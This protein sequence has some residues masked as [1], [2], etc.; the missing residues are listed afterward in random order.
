MNNTLRNLSTLVTPE[1]N[2]LTLEQLA[3]AYPKDLNP[4][5]LATAFSKVFKLIISV[6]KKYY[7]LDQSD[8]ASFSL[9]V[10][11]KCLQTYSNDKGAFTTYFTTVLVNKLRGQCQRLFTDKRKAF[12]CGI[13]FEVLTEKGFDITATDYT[14]V[15]TQLDNIQGF[16]LDQRELQ[17]CKYIMEGY[18]NKDIASKM[19][20]SVMTLCNIR[21]KLRKKLPVTL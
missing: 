8:V 9:Q 15:E 18:N 5:V 1:L 11:D 19:N 17:Y 7:G 4:C 16:G 21:K 10:L 20:T 3:E 12:M 14:A 2:K 6:S 13:S